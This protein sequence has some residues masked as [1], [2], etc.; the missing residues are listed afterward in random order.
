MLPPKKQSTVLSVLFRNILLPT[1]QTSPLGYVV[2]F[3][4]PWLVGLT[5]TSHSIF[6]FTFVQQHCMKINVWGYTEILPSACFFKFEH[7]LNRTLTTPAPYPLTRSQ[8]TAVSY[9]LGWYECFAS[10]KFVSERV[11]T[12]R[13]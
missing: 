8:R 13:T 2:L 4:F 1:P 11:L 5:K 9:L 3:Q 6:S 7:F 12:G 10:V